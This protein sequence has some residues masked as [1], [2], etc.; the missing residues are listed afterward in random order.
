MSDALYFVGRNIGFKLPSLK[1]P[2][3]KGGM[4]HNS[5][6]VMQYQSLTDFR[7]EIRLRKLVFLAQ[8][9]SSIY[10]SKYLNT[11]EDLGQ[12]ACQPRLKWE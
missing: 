4:D 11:S 2:M 3:R 10:A 8:T 5:E 12:W 7:S 6:T 9:L 1:C